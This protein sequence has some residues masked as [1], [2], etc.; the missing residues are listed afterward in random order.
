MSYVFIKKRNEVSYNTA[1]TWF[2]F[3]F[4]MDK[5]YMLSSLFKTIFF[6]FVYKLYIQYVSV[7]LR[8]LPGVPLAVLLLAVSEY[9]PCLLMITFDY[10][11][12][13]S[14]KLPFF[15]TPHVRANNLSSF[16]VQMLKYLIQNL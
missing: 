10:K 16:L 15:H 4:I 14:H 6:L 9:D 3:D 2:R 12:L 13:E 11:F 5:T 7:F 1:P 8:Y